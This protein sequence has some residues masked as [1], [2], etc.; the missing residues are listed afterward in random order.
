PT[1]YADALLTYGVEPTLSPL[2]FAT[3]R[4][5]ADPAVYYVA[6]DGNDQNSG[7]SQEQAWRTVAHAAGRANAGDTIMI[8][9][10]TYT[11][12]IRIRA[13]GASG[14]PIIFKSIPGEQ[15]IFDGNDRAI[16]TAFYAAN[17]QHIH[18][19]GLY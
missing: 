2:A 6:S 13:T 9:G 14:K 7:L 4:I 10:G 18:F 1:G 15:V 11:E 5:Q 3:N 16:N 17:K 8:A 19:D 12:S